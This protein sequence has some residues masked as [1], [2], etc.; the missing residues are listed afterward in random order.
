M[1]SDHFTNRDDEGTT[2]AQ[3]LATLQQN[4]G[5]VGQVEPCR[6]RKQRS[7]G[8]RYLRR[9]CS[10]V[11]AWAA[12]RINHVSTCHLVKADGDLMI[13]LFQFAAAGGI[14]TTV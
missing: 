4:E 6:L 7:Q 5:A 1:R 14:K 12:L 13:S 10:T 9:L 3:V 2:T 8:L 11:A